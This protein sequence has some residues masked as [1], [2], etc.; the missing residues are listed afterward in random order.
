MRFDEGIARVLRIVILTVVTQVA[1]AEVTLR[2]LTDRQ[3]AVELKK[4]E[5]SLRGSPAMGAPSS[6]PV[7]K[8][9]PQADK[10]APSVGFLLMSIFGPSSNLNAEF[11]T[12]DGKTGFLRR[13]DVFLGQHVVDVRPDGVLLQNKNGSTGRFVKPGESLK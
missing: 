11:L 13:G 5:E 4:Y 3:R 12:P 2:D 10:S 7:Q 9:I 8:E 1:H 6:P